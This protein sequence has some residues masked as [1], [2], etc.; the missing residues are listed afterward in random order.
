MTKLTWHWEVGSLSEMAVLGVGS[1]I[2]QVKLPLIY[3]DPV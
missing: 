1:V 3:I 2:E